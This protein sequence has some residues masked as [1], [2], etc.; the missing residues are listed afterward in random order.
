MSDSV[1]PGYNSGIPPYDPKRDFAGLSFLVAIGAIV[2]LFAGLWYLLRR[3]PV[4]TLAVIAVLAVAY[5][6]VT[7][8]ADRQEAHREIVY[9]LM[10]RC[11]QPLGAPDVEV[12]RAQ[13]ESDAHLYRL[14]KDTG[15]I[16]RK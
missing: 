16:T 5:F 10:D 1:G 9:E 8:A 12:C 13:A 11:L 14:D 15:E 7:A 2:G 6:P 3:W 4:Q